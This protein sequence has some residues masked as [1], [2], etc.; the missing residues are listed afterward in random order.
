MKVKKPNRVQAYILSLLGVELG[1]AVEGRPPTEEGGQ[2]VSHDSV[3]SLSAAWA[4]G[5]LISETIATL[6]LSMYERTSAGKRIASL[7]PLHFIIHDQ[8]NPDSTA[9][10]HW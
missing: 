10:V 8:P 2:V 7:H 4:C 3:L 6:P 5:R 9:A 1:E